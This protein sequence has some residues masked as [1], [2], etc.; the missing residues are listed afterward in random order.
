MT[1]LS[2]SS[3]RHESK[4]DSIAYH[5]IFAMCFITFLGVA[6]ISTVLLLPWRSWLPGAEGSE[7]ML[8]GVRAAVYTLM[9]HLI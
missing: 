5:F 1:S 7:T 4:G 2:N 9:S 8:G 3:A 6:L